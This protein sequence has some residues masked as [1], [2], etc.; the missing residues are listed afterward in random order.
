MYFYYFV[1]VDNLDSRY[2]QITIVFWFV[3]C[4]CRILWRGLSGGL[5]W[6]CEFSLAEPKILTLYFCSISCL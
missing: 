4:V 2:V 5:A 6:N 3:F 1:S